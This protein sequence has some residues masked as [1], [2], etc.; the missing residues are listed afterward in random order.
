MSFR[1]S[2]SLTPIRGLEENGDLVLPQHTPVGRCRTLERPFWPISTV[3]VFGLGRSTKSDEEARE[4][5]LG[6]KELE[7]S[8]RELQH[9]RTRT[10]GKIYRHV[11]SSKQGKSKECLNWLDDMYNGS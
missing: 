9:Y 10:D 2:S 5:S 7:I 3:D 1:K 6:T 8:I 11:P 4:W